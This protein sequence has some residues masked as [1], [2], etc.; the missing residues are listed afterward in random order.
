MKTAIITVE[1]Y[2]DWMPGQI[3]LPAETVECSNVC[4]CCKVA[5]S[6]FFLRKLAPL[7][8]SVECVAV[9]YLML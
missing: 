2:K 9:T 7:E 4:G 8:I 5:E 6:C 1:S 3:S